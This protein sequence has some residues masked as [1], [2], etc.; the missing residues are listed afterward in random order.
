MIKLILTRPKHYLLQLKIWKRSREVK[1]TSS[2]TT[3]AKDD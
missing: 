2:R 1:L 3:P